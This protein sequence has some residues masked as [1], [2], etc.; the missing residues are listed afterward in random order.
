MADFS[1][2]EM[3]VLRREYLRDLADSSAGTFLSY[4]NIARQANWMTDA[5]LNSIKARVER[6]W[7]LELDQL[8]IAQKTI[9][10]RAS[11]TEAAADTYAAGQWLD[12]VMRLVRCEVREGQIN[13]TGYL[14]TLPDSTRQQQ[15]LDSYRNQ[16]N[17]DRR[18]VRQR[19]GT[20]YQSIPLE[21]A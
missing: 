16:V 20:P 10:L 2:A 1:S 17:G 13:D 7:D 6:D 3:L 5:D 15:V 14:E 21:R 19:C 12:A 9:R 8:L 18:W 11:D 4:Y